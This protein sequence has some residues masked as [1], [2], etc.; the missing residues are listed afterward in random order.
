MKKSVAAVL[1]SAAVLAVLLAL[2]QP[3]RA[4]LELDVNAALDR[5]VALLLAAQRDDGAFGPLAVDTTMTS[6]YPMGTTALTV[7]AL[8]RSGVPG[9][10][11]AM[12]RA[13]AWLE[14]QPLSKTYSVSL[15]ILALDALA[16]E[17]SQPRIHEAAAWLEEHFDDGD[18]LWAYPE[19]TP[20]ISNTQF[21]ALAL[22]V[23]ARHGYETAPGFWA[24]VV[25]G[26]L[27]LQEE[28]G[29][30]AYSRNRA[31]P[32]TTGGRTA[33]GLATLV[34]ATEFLERRGAGPE[35][36]DLR[37]AREGM[38]RAWTWL[39][40]HFTPTGNPSGP[41]GACFTLHP[42]SR[43]GN[44]LFAASSDWHF[45]YLYAVERVA[46]LG[47]R[48][49]LG[50]R[51]WYRETALELLGSE[52]RAG[53]W[54]SLEGTCLVMLTLRRAT[55]TG[56]QSDSTPPRRYDL[57]PDP[58]AAGAHTAPSTDER[59]V[60]AYT[61][62]EPRGS[63][64]RA[65]YDDDRWH[66][67]HAPFGSARPQG[68]VPNTA[69]T[70]SDLWLRRRFD[71]P[72][73]EGVPR[74]WLLHDDGVRVWLNGEL[75]VDT[76]TWSGGRYVEVPLSAELRRE[77]EPRDNVIAVHARNLGGQNAFDL[78]LTPWFAA[79]VRALHW[80]DSEP[81]VDVP[82][83]ARWHHFG[84]L[85]DP[86]HDRLLTLELPGALRATP[87]DD[88][89]G[90][91]PDGWSSRA[92]RW[93]ALTLDEE[94]PAVHFLGLDLE[95][96]EAVDGYVWLHGSRGVRLWLDGEPLGF[97]H[98]HHASSEA[99]RFPLRVD[100]GTHRLVIALEQ[101]GPPAELVA[102]VAGADGERLSAV[103]LL[104]D[105]EG[106]R[107]LGFEP[108]RVE[109]ERLARQLPAYRLQALRKLLRFDDADFL[110]SLALGGVPVSAP[111]WLAKTDGERAPRG[112]GVLLL[113]PASSE[114]PARLYVRVSLPRNVRSVG[115]RLG[116]SREAVAG[117]RARLGVYD[118]ELH[119]L[120]TLDVMPGA[121]RGA[122]EF[123]EFEAPLEAF[124][125][126]DV[127]LVL[128]AAALPGEW[129]EPLYVDQLTLR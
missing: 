88:G 118:G 109:L 6:V 77:F 113:E 18:E 42:R 39:D 127:L 124:G 5:A 56:A 106:V 9:S 105:G 125:D 68:L 123:M 126:L 80:V 22:Q 52:A 122:N 1:S 46:A 31:F 24:R 75:I 73:P 36:K 119:W 57:P 93:G 98:E 49:R 25:R 81:A 15:L 114:Q 82:A 32:G 121:D 43:V 60:W 71:Q 111:R 55:L 85:P 102:R 23:A 92:A 64:T 62:E 117:G 103:R 89:S 51:P 108:E 115:A 28:D 86:T 29:S 91:A 45:Y 58:E 10:H 94:A 17:S 21:A 112:K 35:H 30:F 53:G 70:S 95:A 54:G 20:D 4:E 76:D 65:G 44:G 79:P 100:V 128:E 34:I 116:C 3:A 59:L 120:A 61:T 12:K 27:A 96:S 19:G 40:A 99:L 63:W 14:R 72:T 129:A 110:E 48:A 37:R 83:V 97:H 26:C 41:R 67:G 50:G 84:S 7:F 11:A 101:W 16:D 38:Q 107:P 47:G 87:E 13:A 74:L 2:A 66:R 33:G 104:V 90:L 8:S 78:R 69:W